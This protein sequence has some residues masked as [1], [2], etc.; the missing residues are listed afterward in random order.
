MFQNRSSATASR[1]QSLDKAGLREDQGELHQQGG[2]GAAGG[3]VAR[4]TASSL[5]AAAGATASVAAMR[6]PSLLGA[7]LMP[8]SGISPAI[9]SQVAPVRKF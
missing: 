6:R 5:M 9:H 8:M 2:D 7:A 4:R 1:L 3:A